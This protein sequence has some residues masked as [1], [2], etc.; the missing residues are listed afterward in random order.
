MLSTCSKLWAEVEEWNSSPQIT[1]AAQFTTRF[2]DSYQ[3]QVRKMK[4]I[5]ETY[6]ETMA[7]VAII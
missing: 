2:C 3:K 6:L 4:R 5:Y 7:Y 1:S